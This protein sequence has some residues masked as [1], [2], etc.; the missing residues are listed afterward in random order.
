MG[1]FRQFVNAGM[2]TQTSPPAAGA[3]AHPWIAGSGWNSTWNTN[4]P[5]DTPSLISA[6]KCNWDDQTWSDTAGSNES[7][8][9]NGLDW[10]TAFAFCAWN[11]K[12]AHRSRVELRRL[13]WE[14][15]AVLSV[16]EPAKI[17]DDQ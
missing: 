17:H 9:E 16:V 7:Q 4:L 12:A 14:R 2:G 11:G 10:Y 13:R 15:P 6:M 3:G 5:A 1:R 8:P